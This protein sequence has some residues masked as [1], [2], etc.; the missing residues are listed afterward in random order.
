LQITAGYQV[1]ID[2]C[3]DWTVEMVFNEQLYG[4]GLKS[5]SCEDG[6][7]RCLFLLGCV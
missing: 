2:V 1:K 3:V 5:N 4:I 7:V 6:A